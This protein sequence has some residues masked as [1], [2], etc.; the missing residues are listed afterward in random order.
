MQPPAGSQVS[1][2]PAQRAPQEDLAPPPAQ[3]VPVPPRRR[4]RTAL[5][6]AGVVLAVVCLSAAATVY[7]LY[8]RASAPDRSAPDVVVDNYL[9]AFLVDRNDARADLFICGQGP[10]GVAELRALRTDLEAREKRFGTTF[11]VKWGGLTVQEREEQAEV[12]VDL[13]ISAFV[14]GI[15]QSDRQSW[16]FITREESDWR[17]CGAAKVG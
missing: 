16:Q 9:R 13:T 17:V 11:S 4:L 6:V 14:D 1:R 12:V 3:P 2:V 7:I 15:S 8:S 5:T 10:D